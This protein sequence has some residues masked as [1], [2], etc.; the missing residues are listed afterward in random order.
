MEAKE[1]ANYI[2]K[3][4]Y[5]LTHPELSMKEAH[6]IAV[7]YGLLIVKEV[8]NE[9]NHEGGRT[10]KQKYWNEVEIELMKFNPKFMNN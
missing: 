10:A 2:F 9:W 8:Q 4:C 5:R 1:K 6:A 7:E 3:K